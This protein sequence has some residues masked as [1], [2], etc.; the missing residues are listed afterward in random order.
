M[1][2]RRFGVSA[3]RR[4]RLWTTVRV[5]VADR[6]RS[7]S[8]N[9]L[10]LAPGLRV[11]D[12]GR[13]QLQIG[14]DPARSLRLPT[15]DGLRRALGFL[16]RGEVPP[17][18]KDVRRALS[19]LRPVLVDADALAPDGV[20]PGDA[21]AAA[22]ADPRGFAHRLAV[23]RTRSV[24][25]VGDLGPDPRPLLRAAGLG[26]ASSPRGADAVLV[27]GTGEPDRGQLDSF[28]RA[29]TVH[30]PVRAV[31]GLTIVGPLVDPGRTAC[32]R[33]VD[34][35]Y[36]A[37]DPLYPGLASL[38]HRVPRHDGVVEPVDTA[39]ATLAVAW[40]VRDLVSHLDGD[41]A[42]TWSATVRCGPGM[43]DLSVLQ[44]LRHPDCGC[45]W[46]WKSDAP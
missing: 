39:L 26:I 5:G 1:D 42:A 45:I 17:K 31:D 43:A 30:L 6:L 10:A 35:H 27:L 37:D 20:A 9:R 25:I 36:A 22:S 4:E 8:M 28:V 38:H 13:D 3:R 34:A 12:R 40:A 32:V 2:A 24:A 44:W 33:C 7:A 19:A 15:S 14:I 23:R 46:V 16:D 41:P 21:A 29:G 18:S 11:L